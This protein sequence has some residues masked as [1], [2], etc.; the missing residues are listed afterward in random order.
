MV[1]VQVSDRDL[2]AAHVGGAPYAFAELF[3]RHYDHLWQTALRASYGREDAADCVQEAFLSAHRGAASF[4][5]DAEV[6]SW[7]HR[8]V[9]NACLDRIRRNKL[10]RTDPLP[11]DKEDELRCPRDDYA[12]LE[13][14]LLVD[15]ALFLLP[16]DQ[17]TAL[18]AVELEG[19]SIADA[20]ALLG[21][22]EGTVKSRCSRGRRRLQEH[23]RDT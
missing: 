23:F 18:V 14:S 22:P 12:A 5:G 16:A 3:R 4:R 21:I 11:E 13:A 2:L 9:M 1:E 8:I 20:A 19:Y 17:R 10:R 15:A 6:R 7:L